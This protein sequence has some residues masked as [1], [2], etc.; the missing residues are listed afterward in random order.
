M[1]LFSVEYILSAFLIFVRVGA[2]MMTAPYFSTS[3]FPVQV[4]LFFAIVTSVLL[5]PRIPASL[6][7]IPLD[8]GVLFLATTIFL[9]V[10]V[11]ATLGLVGQIIFAGLEMGG[12]IISLKIALAF[13]DLVDTMTQQQTTIISNL[14]T[15]LAVLVFLSID[16]DKIYLNALAESFLVVPINQAQIHLAGPYMLELATWLFVIGVQISSPFLIVLLLLDISLAI[17]ARI[18]PQANLMFI[19]LPLKLGIGFLLLMLVIP[20]LPAVFDLFYNRLFE[21]LEQM[22]GIIAPS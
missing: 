8:S 11:G 21:Y 6:V 20:Y 7:L 14:F 12:R 19:A 1:E 13:S 17:F 3:S 10:L 9:E 4:K 5:F 15:L 16:G 2:M 22:M 18:M